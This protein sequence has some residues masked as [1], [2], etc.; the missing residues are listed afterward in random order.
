V[1]FDQKISLGPDETGSRAACPIWTLF[2]KSYIQNKP[3]RGFEKPNDVVFVYIDP[4]NGLRVTE[5]FP[6]GIIEVFQRGTEPH[7]YSRSQTK[8]WIGSEDYYLKFID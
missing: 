7:V 8:K 1:G 6:N 4:A 3:I 2:M 5:A